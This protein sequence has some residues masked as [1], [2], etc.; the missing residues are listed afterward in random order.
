MVTDVQSNRDKYCENLT[1]N[2]KENDFQSLH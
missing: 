2:Q 1:G